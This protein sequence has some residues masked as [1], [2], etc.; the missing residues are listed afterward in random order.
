MCIPR[1]SPIQSDTVWVRIPRRA[2][3]GP[4]SN[5]PAVTDFLHDPLGGELL[6]PGVGRH[7]PHHC[8]R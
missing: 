2:V 7:R 4:V 6:V 5:A 1:L 8:R 3:S